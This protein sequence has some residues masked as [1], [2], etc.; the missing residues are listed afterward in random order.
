MRIGID[1]M[2]GDYAPGVTVEGLK[3]AFK[4]LPEDVTYHLFG[5]QA[6]LEDMMK[7]F[8]LS[9]SRFVFVNAPD[10]VDMGD[11]PMR[12]F[13]NKKESSLVK[14][15]T[16]LAE[17]KIDV[18]CSAGNSGVMLVGAIS[19]IG[20]IPGVI[21]PCVTVLLPREDGGSVL[22]LDV[23]INPECR[24]EV[25]L[26]YGKMGSLF[27]KHVMKIESP[28]V[29]LMNIGSEAKKGNTQ[30]KATYGLMK[31]S[32][33]FEFIGNIEGYDLFSDE[34]PDVVVCDGFVG[35]VILKYT[36][37]LYV[38]LKRRNLVDE[39]IEKF[40]Y[41]HIGGTPFLGINKNII[42]G[43]GISNHLAVKAMIINSYNVE[44]SGIN[45]IFY[46]AFENEK[47]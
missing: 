38:M 41:E 19:G 37:G 17:G 20:V 15:F 12:A 33:A 11:D 27:M 44:M 40:N 30:I 18:F 10:L 45:R 7:D 4:E 47:V 23:G 43:H 1:M 46:N 36:E 32:T 5:D 2:G 16:Y 34:C 9:D 8:P 31:E 24:P 39:H 25:L 35:N 3:L 28:R 26:Q 6:I 42:L 13:A 21:R 22:L 29:G 14:G